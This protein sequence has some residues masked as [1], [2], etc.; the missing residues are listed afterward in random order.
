M[1]WRRPSFDSTSTPRHT[2]SWTIGARSIDSSMSGSE[3]GIV[4]ARGSL[5]VSS[6]SCGTRY[7]A[8]QPV[9]PSP[10]S[11]RRFSTV[12]SEYTAPSPIIATG[13]Q[14]LAVHAVDADVVV[15]DELPQLGG[16]GVADLAHLGEP[17]QPRAEALDR[18]QLGRPGGHP[19]ERPGGAHGDGRVAGEGLGAVEVDL[20]PA[21]RA[22]VG[23]VEHPVDLVPVDERRAQ[24]RVDALL[25]RG[26]AERAARAR[27]VGPDEDHRPA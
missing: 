18:L 9:T 11:T 23:E 22:V 21:V 1:N 14:V 24:Q 25:H 20:A 12:S 17:R 26:G 4:I 13:T 6:T 5:A 2:P 10:I 19:A 7:L 15:V 16:D 27:R 8:T 3:P